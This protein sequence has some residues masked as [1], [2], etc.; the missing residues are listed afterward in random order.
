MYSQSLSS[1]QICG[2]V[3]WV[4]SSAAKLKAPPGCDSMLA[5]SSEVSSL[6]EGNGNIHSRSLS[7]WS[8]RSVW[9]HTV[10]QVFPA[11]RP[12]HLQ[13]SV[14]RRR[15]SSFSFCPDEDDSLIEM[16]TA[17]ISAVSSHEDV[18][19]N[20]GW[21][22]A[23]N[24]SCFMYFTESIISEFLVMNFSMNWLWM[25]S[26][27]NTEPNRTGPV[28]ECRSCWHQTQRHSS[29]TLRQLFFVLRVRLIF[30]VW[31]CKWSYLIN[32]VLTN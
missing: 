26:D 24:M 17:L 1:L 25:I 29:V 10:V 3:L 5:F 13:S 31:I 14:F 20:A 19:L 7:A 30:Y 8:W 4:V 9:H 32:Y 15:S 22:L 2:S 23:Q 27:Q 16:L 18:T 11:S 6:S 28:G 12:S 21:S